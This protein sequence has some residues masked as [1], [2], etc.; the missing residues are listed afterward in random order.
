MPNLSNKFCDCIAEGL[1]LV[2]GAEGR[3]GGGGGLESDDSFDILLALWFLVLKLS[4][5]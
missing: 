1:V 3:E 2:W 5:S 4:W